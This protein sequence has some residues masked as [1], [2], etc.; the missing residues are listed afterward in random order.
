MQRLEKSWR[1]LKIQVNVKHNLSYQYV[2]PT[3]QKLDILLQGLVSSSL[4]SVSFNLP[5]LAQPAQSQAQINGV[6][7]VCNWNCKLSWNSRRRFDRV[8]W[9][10]ISK[11]F[12][13]IKLQDDIASRLNLKEDLAEGGDK[14]RRAAILSE[15][16]KKVGKHI[17]IT[18]EEVG[19]P[20]P[21]SSNQ[22]KLVLTTRSMQ[23]CKR[24][25]CKD[26]LV[27][28]LSEEEALLL[29]L[30]KVGPNIVQSTTIMP[31]LR[32]VVNECAG[33]P[34][35]VVV[36]AGTLK[37]EDDPRIW[38][39]A[40]KELKRRIG[41]VEGVEAKVIECLKFSFDHLKDE[42]VKHCFLYCALYP[43]DFEI[44]K[45]E[46][47]ECW[48]D[49][50][51]IDEMDTRQ[52]MEDKG[53]AFL[54]KLED[55][56]LIE[57]ATSLYDRPCVKMHDAVRDMALSITSLNPR[58]IEKVS[59]ME[60]SISE[61]PEDMSPPN[62]QLLTTLL[63]QHNPIEKIS[64]AFFAD[65][66]HLNVLNLSFTDIESL[67]NS[68]SEL[69]NL[70]TL[71]LG[72]CSQL[73]HVPCLS[74]LQGLKKLDLNRT[75]IE[76]VPEGMDML[77]NLRYLD[78]DE[79]NLKDIPVGL[80]PKLTR[81]QHLK[82]DLRN[83]K[84]SVEEVMTLQNLECFEGYFQD[85]HELNKFLS[86]QQPKSELIMLPFDV[87]DLEFSVWYHFESL[88][89]AIPSLENANRLTNCR[90]ADCEEMECVVSLSLSS[91][92]THPFH[93][94]EKL[95]L[96]DLPKLR[97]VIKVERFESTTIS[98]LTP[99]ATFSCLKVIDITRPCLFFTISISFDLRDLAQVV[100]KQPSRRDKSM[101]YV[102]TTLA[103]INCIGA[104]VCKYT[105]STM[106]IYLCRARNG[107][108]VEEKIQ[109]LQTF[110]DAA[111]S[112]VIDAP[113]V[114]LP[115]PTSVTVWVVRIC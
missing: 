47:I 107:K 96:Y 50:G 2:F 26:I 71:L 78:L 48:I 45:D 106:I 42:K 85:M 58:Y 19:I 104:P 24:M 30:N 110:L 21:S 15:M 9:V 84:A 32:L 33:L 102:E 65:M 12:N 79:A 99:S 54:K 57:N 87:Q 94:L 95:Y 40:L 55:S 27:R 64:N 76:E 112:L 25:G 8:I 61:I 60:N 22:C 91:S 68:I 39:T 14:V 97:E 34:L 70:T 44:W 73:R 7:R 49:E 6:H 63:L 90:I 53:H 67:P 41:M 46:L 77:V 36:V 74:K 11:D 62:S 105:E 66:L 10:T 92:S 113:S 31:T 115:L 59:F 100:Y 29:F 38:K 98:T 35:T 23:I 89:H 88:N 114:G 93:S 18:L 5:D 4:F 37:G 1:K 56:C 72:S 82:I 103:V 86:M 16:L 69:K 17:L 20:E 81:L 75:E 109:E 51:F 83:A 28:P 108:L 13:V 52:D 101:K 43:E 111:E 3:P 80:L